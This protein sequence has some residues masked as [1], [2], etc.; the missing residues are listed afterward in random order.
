M[1]LSAT[2]SESLEGRFPLITSH[3]SRREL[4]ALAGLLEV[5]QIAAG[6]ALITE[7]EAADTL[8]LLV[9]GQL[10]VQIDVAGKARPV[11]LL[12]AG[13]I[14]G[15]VALM[16]PGPASATVVAEGAATLYA[17]RH[18]ALDELSRRE[19][20]VATAILRALCHVLTD[21]LRA[22]DARIS[23]VIAAFDEGT[24][25]VAEAPEHHGLME[26]FRVRFG[27]ARRPS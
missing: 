20:H 1:S 4:D 12:E 17:L 24:A 23:A 3:L 19:P 15:E 14:V 10:H 11:G 7:G 27:S 26:W 25:E 8:Y 16:D 9:E 2:D 22:A 6:E 18:A 5:R 21:R 13:A